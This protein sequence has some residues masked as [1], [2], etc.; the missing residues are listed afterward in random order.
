[1]RSKP[2]YEQ[3]SNSLYSL[4]SS[5]TTAAYFK[6]LMPVKVIAVETLAVPAESMYVCRAAGRSASKM[7]AKYLE[8]VSNDLDIDKG[9]KWV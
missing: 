5:S 6:G 9:I 2:F 8:R 3:K 1:M 4:Y 7:N